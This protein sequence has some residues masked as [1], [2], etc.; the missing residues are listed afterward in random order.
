[1]QAHNHKHSQSH[2][3]LPSSNDHKRLKCALAHVVQHFLGQSW[4]DVHMFVSTPDSTRFNVRTK[5]SHVT[6]C[7]GGGNLVPDF[8]FTAH[9]TTLQSILTDRPE[10]QQFKN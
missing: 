9:H 7:S 10:E 5:F 2:D 1:M 8:V 4:N 6:L 3:N